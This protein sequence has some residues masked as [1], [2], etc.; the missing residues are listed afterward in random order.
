MQNCIIV[1]GGAGFIGSCFVKKTIARGNKVVVLDKLT[2]SGNLEN[3]AEVSAHNNYVFVKG[4]I[5]DPIIANEL[6]EKYNPRAIINFAAESHVDNSISGPAPFIETNIYGTFNLL[7]SSLK[8][9]KNLSKNE[10]E[11]FRFVHISTDEVYGSLKPN[12][13]AFSRSTAYAPNSPYS[14]SKASSDH[15]CRAWFETYNLPV[16]ITNCSN[17]YGPF[18][19]VEK[20]IPKIITNALNGLDIPIY[21]NGENIRDWIYVED[22]VDGVIL[23]LEHG[24]PGEKYLFGGNKELQN[25]D[26][27]YRICDILK[28]KTGVDYGNQIKF[29]TDRLGHDFRYAIDNRESERDLGFKPSHTFDIALEKTVNWYMK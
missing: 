4:D 6:L 10:A 3:L 22:H 11:K 14:A 24:V 17:N 15:L 1:T 25:I 19:H 16:I 2:Y 8:Y 13:L 7:N 5:C 23:A 26:V 27:A 18:Q 21:G 28:K 29:V 9:F 20:L 12:D